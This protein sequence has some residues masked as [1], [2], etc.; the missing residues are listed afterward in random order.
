MHFYERYPEH[1]Q[2]WDKFTVIFMK[3]RKKNIG[4]NFSQ[5]AYKMINRDELGKK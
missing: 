1:L 4:N 2:G 5:I 3:H